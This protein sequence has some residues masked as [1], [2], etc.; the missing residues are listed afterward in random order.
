MYEQST[1]FDQSVI[2]FSIHIVRKWRNR[3]SKNDF[4]NLIM[5]WIQNRNNTN[6]LPSQ[7]INHAG[8]YQCKRY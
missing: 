3:F 1:N 5:I 6:N 7:D 4:V 8:I 2:R